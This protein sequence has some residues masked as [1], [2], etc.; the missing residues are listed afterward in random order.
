MS[1]KQVC[2][3][4]EEGSAKRGAGARLRDA[5]AAPNI[6]CA[7]LF[8]EPYAHLPGRIPTSGAP[9]PPYGVPHCFWGSDREG[10]QERPASHASVSGRIPIK[11]NGAPDPRRRPPRCF[12]TG[13][14]PP[15]IATSRRTESG[16][17]SALVEEAA[18]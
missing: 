3:S 7:E 5:T 15:A 16:R 9:P 18:A 12:V 10:R 4:A 8:A 2:R 11:V 6:G 17:N 14:R 1:R 13:M